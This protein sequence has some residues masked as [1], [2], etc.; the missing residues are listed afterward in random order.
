MIR[1]TYSGFIITVAVV[2]AICVGGARCGFA[3]DVD[4]QVTA[5][6]KRYCIECHGA[7]KPKG[8]FR[9][10]A[11]RIAANAAD[12]ENWQLMLDNLQ[13][14]EMPPKDAK[15]PTP[16]EVEKV[17]G[18]IQSEISRAASVLKGTDGE[19]VLRRLNR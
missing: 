14:G 16:A 6:L 3:D 4:P 11:L 13:L 18:W 10:D 5:F 19:V 2:V 7:T 12:A 8:D 15:Q 1:S 17:I 9:V